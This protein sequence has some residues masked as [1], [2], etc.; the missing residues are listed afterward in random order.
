MGRAAGPARR[1]PAR[2]GARLFCG[3]RHG[4]VSSHLGR[5]RARAGRYAGAHPWPRQPVQQ[6]AQV[7]RGLPVPVIAAIQGSPSAAA[8]RSR[9][10]RTS[11]MSRPRR[12]SSILEFKWGLVP[13]MSGIALM[14]ELARA[15][16]IRELAMTGGLLRHGGPGLRLRRQPPRR[17]ARRRPCDCA[18]DRGPQPRCDARLK[19]LLNGA[20]HGRGRAPARQSKE[21]AALIGSPTRSRRCERAWRKSGRFVDSG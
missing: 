5:P 12:G 20:S 2:R 9:S 4:A 21:Q 18:G 7:W 17:P 15:D 3:P 13:D 11:A 6:A 8:S 10:A 19:R 1:R 16:V 14:R